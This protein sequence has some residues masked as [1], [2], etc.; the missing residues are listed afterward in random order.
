MKRF[1]TQRW[2]IAT[3]LLPLVPL[4]A[5]AQVPISNP[6]I[7]YSSW[8]K[9]LTFP[10]SMSEQIAMLCRSTKP[11]EL[12]DYAERSPHAKYFTQVYVNPIGKEGWNKIAK[13][14]QALAQKPAKVV[15]LSFAVGTV[16]V[17]EKLPNPQSQKPIL[18]TAM[19]KREKGYNPA[20]F[21]WEFLVLDGTGREVKEQGKIERCQSCHVKETQTDGI[22]SVTKLF[23][24][25]TGK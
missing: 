2:C 7:N 14:Q 17:K 6:T 20:C 13:Q 10:M 22:V 15:P 4:I 25:R 1:S 19:R 24:L 12:V 3:F 21:D 11:K 5:L 9:R 23:N 16:V 8:G 18:L